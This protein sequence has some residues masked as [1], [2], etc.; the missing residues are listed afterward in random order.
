MDK[1]LLAPEEAAELLGIGRTKV[2]Q[3]IATGELR[4]VRIDRCRRVTP[5]ALIDFVRTLDGGHPVDRHYRSDN[6]FPPD[7]ELIPQGDDDL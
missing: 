5:E 1:L 7:S 4:S 6:R 2:F 3:L